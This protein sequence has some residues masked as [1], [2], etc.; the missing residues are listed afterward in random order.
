MPRAFL[1]ILALGTL[2]ACGDDDKDTAP[3]D[4]DTVDLPEDTFVGES[5]GGDTVDTLDTDDTGAFYT[6]A[7]EGFGTASAGVSFVGQQALSAVWVKG[8]GTSASPPHCIYVQEVADWASAGRTGTNPL[9]TD[10]LAACPGCEFAFTISVESTDYADA[11]PWSDTDPSDSDAPPTDVVGT[12]PGARR[13]L[14]CETLTQ[15]LDFPTPEELMTDFGT[16]TGLGFD[17]EGDG[18]DDDR[19]G[20][21]LVWGAQDAGWTAAYDA[22]WEPATGRFH[23][24]GLQRAAEYPS[25]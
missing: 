23:W 4:S 17:I 7:Y 13:T 25:Y 24:Y 9:S 11:F 5:G 10:D 21:V 15:N 14:T 22:S 12:K 6:I 19:T 18:D 8:G 2:A 20:V 3:V 16:W 1:A